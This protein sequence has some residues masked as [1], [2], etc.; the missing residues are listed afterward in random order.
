MGC[1]YQLKYH[2]ETEGNGQTR[3]V[4]ETQY[5]AATMSR[6][7]LDFRRYRNKINLRRAGLTFYNIMRIPKKLDKHEVVRGT[8]VLGVLRGCRGT[9]VWQRGK[10]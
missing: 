7:C 3:G 1:T 5:V 10:M 8:G 9:K 6:L 4:R 2:E